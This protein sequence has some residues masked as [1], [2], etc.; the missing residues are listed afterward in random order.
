MIENT[1]VNDRSTTYDYTTIREWLNLGKGTRFQGIGKPAIIGNPCRAE[2]YQLV[3]THLN[4]L[5]CN[6]MRHCP[7]E[8]I[9]SYRV[10]I[11]LS[12]HFNSPFL[13]MFHLIPHLIPHPAIRLDHF[14][15]LFL[16]CDQ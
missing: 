16:S 12:C 14:S 6:V 5:A 15:L 11:K 9:S 4:Q 13:F 8:I 2:Q 7:Y 3:W 10:R 1:G